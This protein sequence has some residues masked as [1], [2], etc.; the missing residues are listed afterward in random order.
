MIRAGIAGSGVAAHLHAKSLLSTTEVD[1]VAVAS[2]TEAHRD[3]F[4]AELGATAYASVQHMLEDQALDVISLALPNRYHAESA[5]IALQRGVHVICEKP[6]AMNLAEADR[7]I[8]AARESGALLLYGEELCFAPRYQKI[9]EIV[10]SGALG[11]TFMIHHQERHHGPYSD[12]F[13]DPDQSG[14]GALMDIAC[15]GVE[16][17]R[18]IKGKQ[19]VRGVFARVGRFRHRHAPVDDHALVSLRFEDGTFATVEGSWAVAGRP[20]DRLEVLGRDGNVAAD[21]VDGSSLQTYVEHEPPASTGSTGR[22]QQGW[23]YVIYDEAHQWG[24]TNQFAH[25]VACIKEEAEPIETGEDGR[26]TLE[27]LMAAY[28]SDASGREVL[29]PLE[30]TAPRPI[31]LWELAE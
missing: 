19:P 20:T 29:L 22:L 2:P 1:V 17:A 28:A 11:P 6:L 26:A 27:I 16:L 23:S 25:F 14:G 8:A 10:D 31:D 3:G 15:H 24:W 4:A 7:M 9:K 21:L 18:W 12:W 13:F 30:S 5:V